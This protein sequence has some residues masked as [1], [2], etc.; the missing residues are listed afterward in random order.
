MRTYYVVAKLRCPGFSLIAVITAFKDE[1][2]DSLR[3]GVLLN[4]RCK[5]I[6]APAGRYRPLSYRS[7]CN[8]PASDLCLT[9]S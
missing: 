7:S 6:P 2:H 5:P 1:T 4:E 3:K 8:H 9:L